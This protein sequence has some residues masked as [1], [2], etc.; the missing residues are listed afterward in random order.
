MEAALEATIL[1]R[2]NA[3]DGAMMK[4]ILYDY[5][6]ILA[7]SLFRIAMALAERFRVRYVSRTPA[8][9]AFPDFFCYILI[10]VLIWFSDTESTVQ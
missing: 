3:T 4:R 9:F 10:W 6:G 2:E 7:T 8:L 5:R 1:D